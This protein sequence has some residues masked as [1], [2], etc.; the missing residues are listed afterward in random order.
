M[1]SL[2]EPE[3]HVL[4]TL[5][6]DGS[7]RWLYP[8]LSMGHLWHARRIVGY[9][10]IA[11]FV[12]LPYIYINGKPPILLDIP[13][14]EFT[15]FGYTFLPTDTL[16]LA[17]FMVS[18]F[19]TIFLATALFGR[20]WCGW[21]CPQTVYM[22]Y[23][24]RPIERFFDGTI[25][26]GGKPGRNISGWRRVARYAVYL[27]IS[28]ALAHIFLS[29]FVGVV[30]LGRWMTQSPIH[31]P[32]PFLVML[33]TTGL[34]LFDFCFF[35]E[36]LCLIACPYGRFQSVLLDRM[37]LIVAYDK[38]RGEPRG[39]RKA[40]SE[41]DLNILGDCIECGACVR[42]CPTG[43]D[44][45][46]GLQMECIHCT[47]CVDACDEIMD[48]VHKPRGLIRYSS[49]NTIDGND[50]SFLRLRTIAYPLVLMLVLSV[51]SYLLITKKSF[52][53]TLLRN[54]G[55]PFSMSEDGQVRNSVRLILVN[56][57]DKPATYSVSIADNDQVSFA[58]GGGEIRLEPKETLT[59]PLLLSAP[60]DV[61]KNSASDIE[62]VVENEQGES[63]RLPWRLLGPVSN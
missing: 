59:E 62:V 58:D 54:F 44:I 10:L 18:V 2:L 4:S 34:M 56:R 5:E 16:L 23:V 22:E 29:Y 30:T 61:F 9:A 33:G 35:R 40:G 46:D 53:A 60:L 21:A 27:V 15:F 55:Q 42:T 1:S 6:A 37:S 43:I 48:R 8:H 41:E 63:R 49:Q 38:K 7:R 52:D 11:I 14:R 45:R 47:Q 31:H 36:Q 12:A 39:K 26:R 24:Y 17:L 20:V 25:G 51:F 32:F 3:E 13:R 19:L 57:T 28:A 50:T